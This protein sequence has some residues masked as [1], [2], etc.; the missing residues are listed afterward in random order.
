[1]MLKVT[2]S[3]TTLEMLHHISTSILCF[4]LRFERD[5]GDTDNLSDEDE[6]CMLYMTTSILSSW[7]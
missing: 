6:L 5:L 4:F 1:M 2:A 7:S 3:S